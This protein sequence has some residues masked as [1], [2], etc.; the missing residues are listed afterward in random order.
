MRVLLFVLLMPEI[1]T[2]LPFRQV[3][4]EIVLPV[5]VRQP[6]VEI[7]PHRH[8]TGKLIHLVIQGGRERLRQ[9]MVMQSP[10]GTVVES[11]GGIAPRHEDCRSQHFG[12]GCQTHG[13]VDH[14]LWICHSYP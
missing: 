8:T 14:P 9:L 7:D 5:L 3:T 10:G 2:A 1:V 6:A 13:D 4:L 12:R 11:L